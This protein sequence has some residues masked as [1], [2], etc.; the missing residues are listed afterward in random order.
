MRLKNQ[1]HLH[2]SSSDPKSPLQGE[3]L[4]HTTH[5]FAAAIHKRMVETQSGVGT[6]FDNGFLGLLKELSQLNPNL[7]WEE[8]IK[9]VKGIKGIQLRLVLPR[10]QRFFSRRM[11]GRF[12][13]FQKRFYLGWSGLRSSREV[14][15][16]EMTFSQG[17]EQCMHW[18]GLPVFKTVYDFSL[19]TMLL[20]ELKPKTI[21]EIGSG[22]GASAIWLADLMQSFELDSTIY[23]IDLNKPTLQ[24]PNVYFIEGDC[25]QIEQA[26][27]ETMLKTAPHPWLLVEDA[28]V[29]VAGVL[30]YFHPY[31]EKGDYLVVEDSDRKRSEIR[32]FLERHSACYKVDTHY[33]D[34]FGRNATCAPDSIFVRV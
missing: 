4:K 14:G 29:N 1:D 34:F 20:W 22:T 8:G 6:F 9:Q 16:L 23:S 21:I 15:I 31:F 32:L 5:Q 27:A 28:H 30:N 7:P 10:L 25:W 19:Y 11:Q 2:S 18:K 33:T 3:A 13:D 26:I 17:I 24:H 12:V